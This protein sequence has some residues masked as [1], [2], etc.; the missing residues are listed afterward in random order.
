MDTAQHLVT[1]HQQ[2]VAE[3]LRS[4]PQPHTESEFSTMVADPVAVL[5]FAASVDRCPEQHIVRLY[6]SRIFCFK[7]YAL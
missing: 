1:K 2:A 4:V 7:T 6:W 3:K 5:M